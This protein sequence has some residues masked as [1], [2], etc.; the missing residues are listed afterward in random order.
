MA[1]NKYTRSQR[2]SEEEEEEMKC[3][4]YGLDF[5]LSDLKKEEEFPMQTDPRENVQA[6]KHVWVS[7]HTQKERY[8]L[9]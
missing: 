4:T 3:P 2:K 5:E 7:A 1:R 6:Y 8:A 9:W